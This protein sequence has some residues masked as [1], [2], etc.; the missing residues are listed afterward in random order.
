M[1]TILPASGPFF[2]LG[3]GFLLASAF[4]HDIMM[5]RLVLAFGFVSGTDILS[6]SLDTQFIAIL[7]YEL[8]IY[9]QVGVEGISG[10][11]D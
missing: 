1:P 11:S 3:V 7:D 5:V 8:P 10:S 2:Q 6:R 4:F 9:S